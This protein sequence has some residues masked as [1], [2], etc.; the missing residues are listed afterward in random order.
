LFYFV[1]YKISKKKKEKMELDPSA[2]RDFVPDEEIFEPFN[3]DLN[4]VE[5]SFEPILDV[6]ED[7]EGKVED[8]EKAVNDFKR[9]LRDD[10]LWYFL[11]VFAGETNTPSI[12]KLFEKKERI[13]PELLDLLDRISSPN[14]NVT[15]P[16][17]EKSNGKKYSRRRF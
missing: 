17:I 4:P 3:E 1:I 6:D 7:E 12:E 14:I 9:Q 15:I 10:P 11:K 8:Y 13:P 16:K 5:I 2:P